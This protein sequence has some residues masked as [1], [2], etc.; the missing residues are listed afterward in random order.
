M[1]DGV[2]TF[3][4]AARSCATIY[5]KAKAHGLN[6]VLSVTKCAVGNSERV[7]GIYLMCSSIFR[8]SLK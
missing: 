7:V 5:E 6:S 1:N 2:E 3:R 8:K 4:D